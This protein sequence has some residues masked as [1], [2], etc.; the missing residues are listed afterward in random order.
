MTDKDRTVLEKIWKWADKAEIDYQAFRSEFEPSPYSNA[1]I[2]TAF[3]L[4]QIG[5]LAGRVSEELQRAYSDIP[6]KQIRGMRNLIIHDYAGINMQIVKDT[7]E[8]DIPHLK[9]QIETIL[10]NER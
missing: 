6:W 10:Q 8:Y 5:E 3:S 4:A 1:A 9:E 2:L 7:I